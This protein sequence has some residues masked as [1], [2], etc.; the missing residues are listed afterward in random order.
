VQELAN[1]FDDVV[2]KLPDISRLK[3]ETIEEVIS[4]KDK[5]KHILQH[6]SSGVEM[7]FNHAVLGIRNKVEVIVTFLAM[8]ELVKK[9]L[10][11]IVQ[12]KMFGDIK[13]K[14]MEIK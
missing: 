9:N 4:I 2:N 13:I 14:K 3:Q 5:I 10:I 1:I 11:V 12:Q 7:T 8:L 6:L